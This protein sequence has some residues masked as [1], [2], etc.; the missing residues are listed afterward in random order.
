LIK[1]QYLLD[2]NI[3][4]EA[5]RRYYHFDICPDFWSIL[6]EQH[7]NERIFSIEPVKAE[8]LPKKQKKKN[9]QE[10]DTPI[11]DRLALWVKGKTPKSLFTNCNDLL[12]TK[13][14]KEI[15]QSVFA[16]PQYR[17][18]AKEEFAA[19][20]DSWLVA[21][22]HAHAMTIVSHENNSP[23]AKKRVLIPAV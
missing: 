17:N 15:I 14:Y 13:S 11:Y 20:A 10:D 1:T 7:Q 23:D 2:S 18:E 22:A 19:I 9:S 5:S 12:V 16:N 8:I 4:I 21:Y 3:F 6:I